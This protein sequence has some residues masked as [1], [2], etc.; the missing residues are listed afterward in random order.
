[1]IHFI[2]IERYEGALDPW[3]SSFLNTLYEKNPKLFPK[4]PDFVIP[5][6]DFMD[7]PKIE[8]VHHDADKVVS[9]YSNDAGNLLT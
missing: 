3:M 1:M 2:P 5:D 9:H 8:I 6:M 4:G 7:R